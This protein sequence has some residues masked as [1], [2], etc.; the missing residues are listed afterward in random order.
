MPDN[1]RLR[2]VVHWLISQGFAFSQEDVAQ[3]LGHNKTYL[4][5]IITGR[6]PM[7][8]KFVTNFCR[9]FNKCNP[10]YLLREIGDISITPEDTLKQISTSKALDNLD[11]MNVPLVPVRGKAG[12]LTGYGDMDYIDSL[13]T[14]PVLVDKTYKGK[15]RCFEVDGDSM[16]DGTRDAICDKD[17]VLGRDIKRE[18]W[19]SK[20]H[21][22]DWN[23]IIVHKDGITI[24][25]ISRHDVE[26]GIIKCHS[27]NSLYDDFELNLNNV[28]ELY[29]LV[30]IID[31]SGKL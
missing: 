20:L 23:F 10:D 17:I 30:K 15:Y 2:R 1:E 24:K 4:S 8:D 25:R 16:D 5:Q 27:L 19:K 11:F 29:N 12:Y 14:M 31:R 21:I 28:I 9:V 13:A 22:N 3:K 26:N 7:S 6:K 18:L